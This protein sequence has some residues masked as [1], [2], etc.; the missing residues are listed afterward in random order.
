MSLPRIAYIKQHVHPK[1]P[2]HF[3]PPSKKQLMTVIDIIA[4]HPE[5]KQNI[6]LMEVVQTYFES[7]I[8]GQGWRA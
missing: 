3:E 1:A 4:E 8:S 5:L 2:I 7:F 6:V